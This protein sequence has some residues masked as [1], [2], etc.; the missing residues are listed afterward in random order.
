MVSTLPVLRTR[1][2]TMQVLCGVNKI[3]ETFTY[4]CPD[5][6][7]TVVPSAIGSLRNRDRLWNPGTDALGASRGRYRDECRGP[8]P[9]FQG[10]RMRR[11]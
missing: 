11:Q 9:P 6:S 3:Y 2:S 8:V 1:R 4:S 10:H 7:C 5:T